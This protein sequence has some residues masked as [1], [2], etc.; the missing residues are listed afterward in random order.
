MKQPLKAGDLALVIGG[1]GQHLS[2]N[3]G[4]IVLVGHRIFGAYGDDHA[5]Y[6]PVHRCT[7]DSV[8]QFSD[9][10]EYVTTGWADFPDVWLRKIEPPEPP[11]I[12]DSA[13]RARDLET[14]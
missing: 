12:S 14:T 3:I 5:Q 6:G 10:G 2:P 8:K 9:N 13:T 1:L 7:G 4:L 11:G